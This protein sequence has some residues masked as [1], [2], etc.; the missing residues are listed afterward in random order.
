MS[1]ISITFTTAA[2]PRFQWLDNLESI[3]DGEIEEI[4]ILLRSALATFF[5]ELTDRRGPSKNT[6]LKGLYDSIQRSA[7]DINK[8]GFTKEH[9]LLLDNLHLYPMDPDEAQK[10]RN[11]AKV[12]RQYLWL[13]SRAIGW[14]YALLILC[15]LGKSRVHKLDDDQRVRI[16]K[17]LVKTRGSLLC[18]RLEDKAVQCNLHQICM[19]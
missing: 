16:L 7:D 3:E 9:R 19:S 17:H 15:A 12:A 8:E 6:R 10:E 5:T 14:S 13:V 1:P 18:R 4:I 11:E 2:N